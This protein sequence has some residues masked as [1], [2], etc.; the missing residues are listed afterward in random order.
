MVGQTC[1]HN[2]HTHNKIPHSTVETFP[3]MLEMYGTG[4]LSGFT[5]VEHS[6]ECKFRESRT[7]I[8]R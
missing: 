6:G 2:T 5:R 4:T 3:G 7:V 1:V 8:V